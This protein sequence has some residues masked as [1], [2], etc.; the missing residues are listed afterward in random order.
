MSNHNLVGYEIKIS[1]SSC[2][3]VVA[4]VLDSWFICDSREY[5]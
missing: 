3:S 5:A 1:R 2:K 4:S